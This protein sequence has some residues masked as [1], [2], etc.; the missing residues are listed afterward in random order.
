MVKRRYAKEKLEDGLEEHD[1]CFRPYPT[2]FNQHVAATASSAF[3]ESLLAEGGEIYASS[4][5]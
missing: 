4:L 5:S 2:T 1:L 3:C